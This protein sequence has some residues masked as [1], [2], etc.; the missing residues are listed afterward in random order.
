MGKVKIKISGDDTRVS[1]SS[2][3]FVCSIVILEEGKSC[4][5]SSGVYNTIAYT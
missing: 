2:N 5:S 3:L 4:L 1:H